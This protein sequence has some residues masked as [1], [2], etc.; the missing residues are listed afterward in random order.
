MGQRGNVVDLDGRA[1]FQQ[2]VAVARLLTGN[3]V[4][5]DHGRPPGQRFRG[6]QAAWFRQH[7]VRRRHEFIHLIGE[8]KDLDTMPVG[9]LHL[10]EL[11]FRLLIAAGDGHD[12]ERFFHVE[13]RAI[14]LLDRPDA[15]TAG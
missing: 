11:T 8:A 7:Q 10:F 1:A 12:F 9:P 4:D 13:E 3:R 5:N 6:G 14:Q 2:K 15:E